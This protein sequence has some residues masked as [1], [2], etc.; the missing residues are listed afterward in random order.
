MV[1]L[2]I[3][4][5]SLIGMQNSGAPKQP[6]PLHLELD[7]GVLAVSAKNNT[8]N[9]NSNLQ[10]SYDFG[11]NTLQIYGGYLKSS[12]DGIDNAL[13]WLAGARYEYKFAPRSRAFL[14]YNAE[15][16]PFIGYVQRDNE[17]LGYRYMI[18]QDA[19]LRWWAEIGY[20]HSHTVVKNSG[21]LYESKVHVATYTEWTFA[22]AWTLEGWMQVIPNFTTPEQDMVNYEIAITSLVN[23]WIS[24]RGAYLVR[25]M[26][27]PYLNDRYQTI[28]TLNLVSSF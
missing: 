4:L 22:K 1:L 24:L 5:A 6:L 28:T 20:L 19:S 16:D 12:T 11:R 21:S 7:A 25:Y 9:F 26:E 27:H 18:H 17:S 10:G 23:P 14:D 13:H 8:Q 3:A 2:L 15:S